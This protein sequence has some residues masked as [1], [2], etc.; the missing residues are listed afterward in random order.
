MSDKIISPEI[1][2]L[3]D[4]ITQNP[5]SRL[6]VPLAEE[7][8]KCDMVDEAIIVLVEGIK[9]HSNYVAARVMLGKIYLQKNQVQE[10]QTE[11]E[12]VIAS[13]PDNILALKKL[14]VIYQGKG[15]PEKALEA[16]KKVSAIDPSDKEAK[17]LAGILEKAVSSIQSGKEID[18]SIAPAAAEPSIAEETGAVEADLVASSPADQAAVIENDPP[19]APFQTAPPETPMESSSPVGEI[20]GDPFREQSAPIAPALAEEVSATSGNIEQET[21]SPPAVVEDPVPLEGLSADPGDS[22]EDKTIVGGFEIP[23]NNRESP[24]PS[25]EERS[26]EGSEKEDPLLSTTLA[27]L[28]MSQG[29]YKEAANIYEKLLARDAS[30]EESRQGLEKALQNLVPERKAEASSEVSNPDNSKKKKLHRL[31]SWL[32]SIRKK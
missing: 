1:I 16:C 28:Y 31:Q 9:N 21:E 27:S 12:Q 11:F 18:S 8:L 17:A 30:D 29:H 2:K 26:R 10:A 20:A 5:A 13:N 22:W 25:A 23:S 6:F 14:A 15:E 7:Y 24:P 19:E 4:K 3:M 32:D